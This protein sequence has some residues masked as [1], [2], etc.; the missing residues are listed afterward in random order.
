MCKILR[1]LT[2]NVGIAEEALKIREIFDALTCALKSCSSVPDGVEAAAVATRSLLAASAARPMSFT[3]CVA[4][5]LPAQ[6]VVAGR[7]LSTEKDVGS[8]VGVINALVRQP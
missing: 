4:S 5:G 8:H 1:N 2:N 7:A 6:L 3:A